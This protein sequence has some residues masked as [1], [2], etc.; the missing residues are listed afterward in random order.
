MIFFVIFAYKFIITYSAS[1]T[2]QVRN[3]IGVHLTPTRIQVS[4]WGAEFYVRKNSLFFDSFKIRNLFCKYLL[5]LA[6]YIL[7]VERISD[8][9]NTAKLGWKWRIIMVK[10]NIL[11]PN[12]GEQFFTPTFFTLENIYY[13]EKVFSRQKKAFLRKEKNVFLRQKLFLR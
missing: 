9:N 4:N 2:G 7:A 10:C 3:P 13:S 12:F 11:Q 1:F 5:F 8:K 6:K